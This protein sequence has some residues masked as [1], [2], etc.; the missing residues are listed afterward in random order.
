MLSGR[1]VGCEESVS[2]AFSLKLKFV[3]KQGGRR[4]SMSPPQVIDDADLIVRLWSGANVAIH[5]RRRSSSSGA[6][7]GRAG[8]PT[9]RTGTDP[10]LGHSPFRITDLR[11]ACWQISAHAGGRA[12][13]ASIAI[14]CS[15]LGASVGRSRPEL[16]QTVEPCPITLSGSAW[17]PDCPGTMR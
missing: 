1:R 13:S 14:R 6:D 9:A 3:E 8:K 2:Q 7:T 5:R 4:N 12:A 15:I 11:A 10:P 16:C 17:L